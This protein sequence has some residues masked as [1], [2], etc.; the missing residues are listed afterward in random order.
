[1]TIPQGRG[2]AAR[3]ID[4]S[5]PDEMED[6]LGAGA[7]FCHAPGVSIWLSADGLCATHLDPT[8]LWS[9][10]SSTPRASFAHWRG[11]SARG[12]GPKAP[13]RLL[14]V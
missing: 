12:A 14:V 2:A 1:M 5:R 11:S 10:A 9:K 3:K 8:E 7:G 6:G 4:V 13:R